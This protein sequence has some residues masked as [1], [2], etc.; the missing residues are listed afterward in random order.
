MKHLLWGAVPL[1][2]LALSGCQSKPEGQ[3]VATVD[4]QAI[5]TQGLD[6]EL[7]DAP[8]D[9]DHVAYRKTILPQIVDRTLLAQA[10]KKMGIDK[11]PEFG[12]QR[13]REEQKLLVELL[14][15]KLANSVPLPTVEA[16]DRY[17]AAHPYEFAQRQKFYV[18]QIRFAKTAST[19]ALLQLGQ[20]KTLDALA[21]ALTNNATP[22]TR[23]HVLIDSAF[24]DPAV[25]G[26]VA[27]QPS[28]D[29]ILLPYNGLYTANVI[30]QRIPTPMTG[31]A[32]RNLAG[33][34]LR[35]K[36]IADAMGQTLKKAR[37]DATIT[38]QAGYKPDSKTPADSKAIQDATSRTGGAATSGAAR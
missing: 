37:Q 10:A 1:A 32:A 13:D 36:A 3:A 7:T 29:P 15:K 28:G 18:D 14:A 9:V 21:A 22:F 31:N 4:G 26:Q 23:D 6:A 5:T 33:E 34:I 12:V 38:Y 11:S 30:I 27:K 35:R 16:V 8:S 20:N 24:L 17:I 25:A 2:M 19:E